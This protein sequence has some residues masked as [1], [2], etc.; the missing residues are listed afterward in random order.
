VR[1]KKIRIESRKFPLYAV[2]N[3][4]FKSR[5]FIFIEELILENNLK[6]DYD[7]VLVKARVKVIHG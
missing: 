4:N 6:G 7:H 2:G 1:I 3:Y 5:F